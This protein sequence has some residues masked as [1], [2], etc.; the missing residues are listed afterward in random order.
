MKIGVICAMK[1]EADP[2]VSECKVMSRTHALGTTIYCGTLHGKDIVIAICG[3]GKTNAAMITQYVIDKYNPQYIINTGIGGSLSSELNVGD[4]AVAD[5][6]MH[7]DVD[8]TAL[9]YEHGIIPDMS[10]SIF[11]CDPKLCYLA[12]TS[13]KTT[14]HRVGT[15]V[16]GDQFIGNHDQKE[17]IKK[18][19]SHSDFLLCCEMEGA[20]IGQVCSLN[21]VP[22]VVVRSIS[23]NADGEASTDYNKFKEIAINNSYKIVKGI[24][25]RI[26]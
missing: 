22:F 9:G 12:S 23:D 26:I 6:V 17:L 13:C 1:E 11:E 3:V 4:V 24:I 16:S 21:Q 2:L 8:V 19:L 20:S 25:Q 7:H 15:I 5:C 18:S 10:S 14:N